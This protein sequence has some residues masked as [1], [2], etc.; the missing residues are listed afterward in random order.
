MQHA[1]ERVLSLTL[2]WLSW[3]VV[4]VVMFL[5]GQSY[6]GKLPLVPTL[7]FGLLVAPVPVLYRARRR[8]GN[9]WTARVLVALL[10]AVAFYNELFRGFLPG[11]ALLN[12]TVILLAGLL[13]GVRAARWTLVA[14]VSSVILAGVLFAHGLHFDGLDPLY[15]PRL[16]IVWTRYAVVLAFVG[17]AITAALS[18][19]I[20]TLES[21]VSDLISSVQRE[22]TEHAHRETALRVI[23]RHERLDT[24]AHLAGGMAHDFNNSLMVVMSSA[25]MIGLHPTANP[26]IRALAGVILDAAQSSAETIQRTLALGRQSAAARKAT[27]IDELATWLEQALHHVLPPTISLALERHGDALVYID[28]ARIQQALLNLCIN[29]RDAMPEGG[30]LTIR[31]ETRD[32]ARV[33]PG[34]AAHPG[35][36]AVVSVRDTGSGMD[37]QTRARIFEPFFTTKDDGQGTGLGLP[38][39]RAAVLD[40]EGFLEVQSSIARGSRF[41]LY[42]PRAAPGPDTLD[43]Q[44]C[45]DV[46]EDGAATVRA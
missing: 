1:R 7:G 31:V 14:C 45:P 19:M 27:P 29:A 44:A 11:S 40:S 6:L 37:A 34:W 17:G 18:Y 41:D 10:F 16:P 42:L 25:E 28:A 36:F 20:D 23:E 46:A 39:V 22:R 4:P 15:D 8:I 33:P 32:V 12:V 5:V 43:R 2:R 38:M 30:T 3:A 35:S 21:A 9:L 24:L 26:E 13:F